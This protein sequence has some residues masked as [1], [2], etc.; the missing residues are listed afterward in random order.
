[1][2]DISNSFV[3]KLQSKKEF[4]LI[5]TDS[6]LGG[7]S[8]CAGIEQYINNKGF[9]IPIRLIFFNSLLASDKG[10]NS[11]SSLEE[12][13]TVFDRA[14]HGMVQFNPDVILIAC[15]TLSVVYPYTDFCS[16]ASIPVIGIIEA[17]VQMMEKALNSQHES[18]VIILGTPITIESKAHTKQLL[19]NGIN[20]N[21][22]INQACPLLESAIQRNPNSAEVELLIDDFIKQAIQKLDEIPDFMYIALCCT[23]YGYSTEVFNKVLAKFWGIISVYSIQILLWL[24]TYL[25]NLKGYIQVQIANLR[26]RYIAEIFWKQAI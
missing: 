19:N 23:H 3:T 11:M 4:T 17:G 9:S 16:S 13:K 21:R 18:K 22:I 12:R 2:V 10:Y 24:I 25:K 15:N 7:L 5:V 20:P 26:L 6:G 14:L 8:V 1:M